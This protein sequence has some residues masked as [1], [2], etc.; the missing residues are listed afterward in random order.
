[1][2]LFENYERRIDQINAALAKYDI[3][4]LEG[5][6]LVQDYYLVCSSE[7]VFPPLFFQQS[8]LLLT[9]FLCHF[10]ILPIL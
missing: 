5:K 1:M 6:V 3:K 10:C 4:Y 9:F 8:K 2:A 7:V